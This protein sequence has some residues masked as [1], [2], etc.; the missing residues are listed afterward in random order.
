[1]KSRLTRPN[2]LKTPL[3]FTLSPLL[4]YLVK[5]RPFSPSPPL[6]FT[7]SKPLTIAPVNSNIKLKL[8][9]ATS[10]NHIYH[11]PYLINTSIYIC[12]FSARQPLIQPF[13][14]VTLHAFSQNETASF[15]IQI[16]AIA[17][18]FFN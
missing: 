11:L 18:T 6:L 13:T 14:L 10:F 1:M 16:M 12:P 7:L 5:H 9:P 15:V 4:F 2:F 17:I 8:R 3:S